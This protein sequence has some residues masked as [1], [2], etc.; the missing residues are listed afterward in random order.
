MS[1]VSCVNYDNAEQVMN[2]NKNDS[3]QMQENDFKYDTVI[4][5]KHVWMTK[6]LDVCVFRNGD[7]IFHA[8]TNEEWIN[9]AK[10]KRPAWC[11]YGNNEINQITNVEELAQGM[12]EFRKQKFRHEEVPYDTSELTIEKAREFYEKQNKSIIDCRKLYNWYAVND[13]RGLSPEGWTI[14]TRDDFEQLKKHYGNP[15]RVNFTL[16]FL[17]KY[18]DGVNENG[19]NACPCGKRL[20]NGNFEGLTSL[21]VFWTN[22]SKDDNNAYVLS[23]FPSGGVG[24]AGDAYTNGIFPDDYRNKG[25]GFSV[26]CIKK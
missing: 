2:H 16:E 22:T 3:L 18:W 4:I 21:A 9:A 23:I 11:Y 5:G 19:F 12:V 26:R 7:T 6:N 20:E 14:P 17:N 24:V 13:P 15:W 10:N 25:N 8:K 1:F